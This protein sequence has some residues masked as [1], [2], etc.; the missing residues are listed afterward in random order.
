MFMNNAVL[1]HSE[2]N[3]QNFVENNLKT[4][5]SVIF[6]NTEIIAEKKSHCAI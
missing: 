2:K 6:N 1:Q 4:F 5:N 3:Q